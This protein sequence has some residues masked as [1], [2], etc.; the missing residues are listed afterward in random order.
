MQIYAIICC[1]DCILNLRFLII[2]EHLP[3]CSGLS[4]NFSTQLQARRKM[5]Q[6]T[7]LRDHLRND[8]FHRCDR[9][10]ESSKFG[11]HGGSHDQQ[12]LRDQTQCTLP[13]IGQMSN[14]TKLLLALYSKLD[15]PDILTAQKRY[16]SASDT[17]RGI[18]GSFP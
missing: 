6:S 7:Q 9:W 11:R 17:L 12:R 4:H 18:F 15:R 3:S 1:P 13:E 14:L 2:E 8:R 5:S 10:E 16:R